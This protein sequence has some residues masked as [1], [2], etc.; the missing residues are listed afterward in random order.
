VS[1]D[2]NLLAQALTALL[3]NAI[4]YNRQ[5]GR[6]DVSTGREARGALVAVADTGC[7][8]AESDL[9][10]VFE[11]FYRVDKSREGK[12]GHSGLGLAIAAAIIQSHG[13]SIGVS[14]RIQVGSTFT[15]LFPTPPQPTPQ[16]V[17]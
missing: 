3:S 4:E 5:N 15:I 12:T 7:G 14:S 6:I 9:P 11:R 10:H 8:I 2:P 1:G 16:S 13:G 17:C